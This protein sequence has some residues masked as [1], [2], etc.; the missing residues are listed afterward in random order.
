VNALRFPRRSPV[1]RLSLALGAAAV[2]HAGLLG[3]LRSESVG[4]FGLSGPGDAIVRM[5]VVNVPTKRVV[6]GIQGLESVDPPP[7]Q[8]PD[9]PERQAVKAEARQGGDDEDEF[10]DS[11]QLTLRPAAIDVVDLPQPQPDDG[12][13]TG[14]ALFTLFVSRD[15]RVVRVRIDSSDLPRE[16]EDQSRQAFFKARFRPGMIGQRP[17][18]SRMQVEIVFEVPRLEMD[19][20]NNAAAAAARAAASTSGLL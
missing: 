20:Q 15:G 12:R 1:A 19:E 13:A 7:R 18:D 3:M 9:V 11:R 5:T 10:A 2:V 8:L 4:R 14:K 16:I 6:E 17:V